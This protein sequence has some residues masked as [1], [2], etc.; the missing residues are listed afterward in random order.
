[1]A[2]SLSNLTDNLTEGIHKIK[3]KNCFLNLQ[4]NLFKIYHL[5]PVKFLSSPG[6]AWK[7]ALKRLK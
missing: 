2:T 6:L 7:A 1:M 5:D 4:K 3:R